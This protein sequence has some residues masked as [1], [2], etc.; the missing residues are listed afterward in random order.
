MTDELCDHKLP[1]SVVKSHQVL[2]VKRG[3]CD[4]SDKLQNIPTFMPSSGALQVVIVVSYGQQRD[5][6]ENGE[7][8]S[9]DETTDQDDA[10]LVRPY[11]E[12]QQITPAG[13]PRR[14]PLP[15][16][17][18]GGGQNVY[19]A[20]KERAVGVGVKRRYHVESGGV[21]IANLVIV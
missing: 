14:N 3:G 15:M 21:R 20:F 8:G 7:S 6:A 17:L 12:R 1:L 10:N 13:L 5:A 19:D 9:E 18:V 4:F 2:V 11:L 16:L